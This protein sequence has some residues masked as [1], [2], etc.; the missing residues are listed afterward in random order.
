MADLLAK[1]AAQEAE[2]ERIRAEEDFLPDPRG[3][4]AEEIVRALRF[5]PRTI[6]LLAVETHLERIDIARY[7]EAL[8]RAGKVLRERST[9]GSWRVT[10][11]TSTGQQTLL[12]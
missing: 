2:L 4:N 7:V 6:E 11:V 12:G 5:G 10:L 3:I 8:L 1:L 9:G